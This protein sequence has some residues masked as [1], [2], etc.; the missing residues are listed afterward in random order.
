MSRACSSVN[1]RDSPRAPSPLFIPFLAPPVTANHT[2]IPTR[3]PDISSW[4]SPLAREWHLW[5]TGARWE[6]NEEVENGE[7]YSTA[8]WSKGRFALVL[9]RRHCGVQSVDHVDFEE[10]EATERHL[11][12]ACSRFGERR[13][14]GIKVVVIHIQWHLCIEQLL[15]DGWVCSVIFACSGIQDVYLPPQS[16]SPEM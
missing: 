16:S 2:F 11:R 15:N 14:I 10:A 4:Q 1:L 3:S 8:C 13:H 9:S 12:A 6:R 7:I 5:T